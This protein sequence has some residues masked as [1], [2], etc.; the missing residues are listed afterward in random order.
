VCHCMMT[1]MSDDDANANCN[2]SVVSW[3]LQCSLAGRQLSC[4]MLRNVV[5][6]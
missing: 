3:T 4:L 5:L 6:L 1:M 2:S